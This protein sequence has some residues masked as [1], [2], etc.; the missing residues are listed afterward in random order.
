MCL[1][2]KQETE[3]SAIKSMKEWENTG[4]NDCTILFRKLDNIP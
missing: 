2:H 3:Y 1:K 4:Q